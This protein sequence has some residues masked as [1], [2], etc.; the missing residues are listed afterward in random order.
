MLHHLWMRVPFEQGFVVFGDDLVHRLWEYQ[1]L[2]G[3]KP[4][5]IALN[6]ALLSYPRYHAAFLARH[7]FDP[8]EGLP[9][10][11]VIDEASKRAWF[12]AVTDRINHRSPLPV[13]VFDPA[14]EM[15]WPLDKG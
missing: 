8:L 2:R 11:S 12:K 3:E 15:I 5:V 14:R 1:L 13:L 9:P 6:P 4:R 10:T 7:G